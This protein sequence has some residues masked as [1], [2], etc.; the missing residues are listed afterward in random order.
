[1]HFTFRDGRAESAKRVFPLD[2]PAIHV[3][4][5]KVKDVDARHKAGHDEEDDFHATRYDTQ[6]LLPSG[7]RR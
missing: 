1:L 5:A 7:S 3:F 2:I 6:S 4:L